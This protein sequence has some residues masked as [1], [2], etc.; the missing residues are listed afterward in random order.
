M[1][2]KLRKAREAVRA[3]KGRCEGRKAYGDREGEQKV[4]QLIKSLR[5][6]PKGKN[7]MS[8]QKIADELN[9]Q[10]IASRAGKGWHPQ[11]V[12]NIINR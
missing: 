2:K 5:K 11:T 12:Y 7:R 6:K 4:V 10:E 9:K 1:M 8:C 3:D